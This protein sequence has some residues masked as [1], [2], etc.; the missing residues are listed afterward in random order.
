[1]K[2]NFYLIT[3]DIVDNKRRLKV[4]TALE[5]HGE[6]V[7]YSVFECL[8]ESDRLDDLKKRLKKIIHEEEDS[9]RIYT[10]CKGCI[11]RVEMM[12]EGK[13]TQDKDFYIV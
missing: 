10:L 9:I 5:D 2:S 3:Y 13:L 7:Q 8:L 11:E 12:G 1:M 4:A 6:R